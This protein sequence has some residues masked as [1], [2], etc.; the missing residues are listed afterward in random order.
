MFA[1]EIAAFGALYSE[2][3]SNDFGAPQIADYGKAE[4]VIRGWQASSKRVETPNLSQTLL[5]WCF[6]V[7]SLI[8]N[9]FAM[10][11]LDH[12]ETT[13]ETI[14]DSRGVRPNSC[15]HCFPPK[16]RKSV[17]DCCTRLDRNRRSTL[18]CSD[19]LKGLEQ[20]GHLR[21]FFIAIWDGPPE[22]LKHF[23]L[24]RNHITSSTSS[25]KLRFGTMAAW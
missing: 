3:T 5:K 15:R 11:L 21:V 17:R 2:K 19:W 20:S 8:L 4:R 14:C 12:P 22:C 24:W 6:T 7:C 13:A 1:T 18:S 9:P 25:L 23:G 10:S 16:D